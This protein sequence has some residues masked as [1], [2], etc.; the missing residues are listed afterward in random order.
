MIA[1][2]DD[3]EQIENGSGRPAPV[4]EAVDWGVDLFALG[5]TEKP[6]QKFLHLRDSHA[7][8]A[9]KKAI[10]EV[11]RWFN[12]LDGNFVKDFQTTGY[13]ARLWELYL[14]ASFVELGFDMDRKNGIPDF[15]LLRGQ[16]RVFVEAVTANPSHGRQF[17]ITEPAPPPP[18]DFAHY[19]EHEMPQK[20]GS[21]LRSKVLKEY[22]NP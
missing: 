16:Q 20:F 5:L 21:P 10:S 12:D 18:E 7:S 8:R 22:W 11:A 4:I 14:F 1:I 9:T 15:R 2:Q 19:I 17:D 6:N 13:D 3:L